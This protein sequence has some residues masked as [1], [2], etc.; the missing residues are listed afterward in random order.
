MTILPKGCGFHVGHDF[1]RALTDLPARLSPEEYAP[2]GCVIAYLPV[3]PQ[4]SLGFLRQPYWSGETE[5]RAVVS[6]CLLVD[7]QP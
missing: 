7:S 4:S 2:P 3:Q 6:R 1:G 5:V